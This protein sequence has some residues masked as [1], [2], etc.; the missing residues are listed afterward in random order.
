M[1]SV[2]VRICAAEFSA[3]MTAMREWLEG[4]RLDPRALA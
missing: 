1:D 3:T 4:D 2:T